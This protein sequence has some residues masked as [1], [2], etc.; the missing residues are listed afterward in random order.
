MCHTGV[1]PFGFK[2]REFLRLL[3]TA[4]S[5]LHGF[6]HLKEISQLKD[7]RLRA[8]RAAAGEA[9]VSAMLLVS[10]TDPFDVFQQLR[11]LKTWR[12]EWWSEM[13][14]EEMLEQPYVS[15]A[16]DSYMR[17]N[18]SKER[19][20][21]VLSM[22]APHFPVKAMMQIFQA[23]KGTVCKARRLHA[24][25][26]G[27]GFLAPVVNHKGFK[28]DP[29]A[30]A[31]IHEWTRSMFGVKIGDP[32]DTALILQRIV[33][34]LYPEYARMPRLE[35]PNKKPMSIDYFYNH[36]R[37][38][39]LNEKEE[40]CYCG[41]CVDGWHTIIASFRNSFAI[42]KLA[43]RSRSSGVRHLTASGCS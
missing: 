34:R 35:M 39:F 22:V 16:R 25:D 10:P 33:A 18:L 23:S 31:Y 26:I 38:G 27:G 13:T 29:Q 4:P 1:E 28:V 36:V 42:L 17:P 30:F 19:K 3:N 11:N 14:M 9:F 40:T 37:D 6:N 5:L 7:R 32:S 8:L 21:L 24:A 20:L 41:G 43:W 15:S 12:D 2:E